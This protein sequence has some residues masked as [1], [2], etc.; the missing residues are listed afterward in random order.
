MVVLGKYMIE[1]K[2]KKALLFHV[3][4]KPL[5]LII[6]PCKVSAK[7]ALCNSYPWPTEILSA[8]VVTSNTDLKAQ[9]VDSQSCPEVS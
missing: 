3:P 8:F 2:R 9:S 4:Q 5:H 7:S 6:L 1:T